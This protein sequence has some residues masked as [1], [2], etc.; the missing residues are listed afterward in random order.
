MPIRCAALKEGLIHGEAH[1]G[2]TVF[3][4]V[5]YAAPPVGALRFLPPQ[6]V[7]PW[8]GVYEA[9][10][11]AA[12]CPQ[13][14]QM[15]G[16]FYEKEFYSPPE[17]R[18]HL[19][20]DCL[21]LNIWTPAASSQ[22]NLPVAL[23]IHGGAFD[24][25]FGHEIE[26][27]GEVFCRRGVILVTINYRLNIFGFFSHPWMGEN[28]DN[29]GIRDQIAALAWVREHIRAFGGDP[30]NITV[31]GQSAGAI[32]TQALVSSPLTKGLISKAIFQSAGGYGTGLAAQ[33]K[34]DAASFGI[35]FAQS[36]GAR[37]LD[38]LRAIPA[39]TLMQKAMSF[40]EASGVSLPFAPVYG[41][42]VLPAPYDVLAQKGD[43][44]DIPYILG[45]T[46]NDILASDESNPIQSGCIAW[47]QLMEKIGRKPS[48]VYTFHRAL[49]GDDAGAFHSS[50]L[51][52]LFGTLR[53]CW[54]PFTPG[55]E[56]LSARM[57]DA[58]THF[59]KCGTPDDDGSWLPCSIDNPYVQVFDIKRY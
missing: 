42:E 28:T 14:P 55:D 59:M 4:G 53:R 31:F 43:V 16:S 20:E 30:D 21:Y 58:W 26:F 35:A 10:H 11:F 36:I 57:T 22:A 48:Y 23:W 34:S 37:S 6:P 54:R 7:Q 24:H 13:L 2:Y 9:N 5:P 17:R 33:S 12:A 29:L 46:R 41:T 49:P 19:D 1:D 52:Y 39:I 25:G 32:S 40:A 51:W 15:P 27:D 18:P 47:S 3:K 45:A 38:D 56:V 50:E 8:A 44:A